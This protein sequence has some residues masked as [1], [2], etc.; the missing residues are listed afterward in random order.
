MNAELLRVVVVVALLYGVTATVSNPTPS[1]PALEVHDNKIYIHGEDVQ[2][3]RDGQW[4]S[5]AEEFNASDAAQ[6]ELTQTVSDTAT[7]L[8]DA[9]A[10]L[11]SLVAEHGGKLE[12]NSD[13]ITSLESQLDT[14]TTTL[15]STLEEQRASINTKATAEEAASLREDLSSLQKFT[16]IL[17]NSFVLQTGVGNNGFETV[18]HT[19]MSNNPTR[20]PGWLVAEHRSTSTVQHQLNNE[21]AFSGNHGFGALHYSDAGTWSL[22]KRFSG[23]FSK[24][25]VTFKIKVLDT[26]ND[27]FH[28]DTTH[29]TCEAQGLEYVSEDD[30]RFWLWIYDGLGNMLDRVF[31]PRA[32]WYEENGN[33]LGE[34]TRSPPFNIIPAVD[35]KCRVANNSLANDSIWVQMEWE[36]QFSAGAAA[37]T[38]EFAADDGTDSCQEPGYRGSRNAGIAVDDFEV[39][40]GPN[41]VRYVE[42][43]SSQFH[44]GAGYRWTQLRFVPD[45]AS[46]DIVQHTLGWIGPSSSVSGGTMHIQIMASHRGMATRWFQFLDILFQSGDHREGKIIQKSKGD[47]V[48]GYDFVSLSIQS[49]QGGETTVLDLNNGSDGEDLAARFGWLMLNWRKHPG[50]H[51]TLQVNYAYPE[52]LNFIPF[53]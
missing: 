48:G 5:L 14:T 35:G 7:A 33:C 2:F 18:G 30:G 52:S 17:A 31:S 41:D 24:Q 10:A 38:F 46:S 40:F 47:N 27:D 11:S 15:Q 29:A 42:H 16:N 21:A 45:G 12:T 9:H 8:Q 3:I 39:T 13:A 32:S 19:Q 36:Y 44:A 20:V 6:T 25:N 37:F 4:S 34:Q 49:Y 26:M 1:E 43:P 28:P 22:F 50:L 23:D 51:Y 53:S